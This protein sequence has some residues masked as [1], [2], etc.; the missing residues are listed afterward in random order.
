MLAEEG[1]GADGGWRRCVRVGYLLGCGVR[2][3]LCTR[4]RTLGSIVVVGPQAVCFGL[5]KYF[6]GPKCCS[7]EV[8]SMVH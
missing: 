6:R 4:R 5:L 1:G 8:L 7:S 3:R 2:G